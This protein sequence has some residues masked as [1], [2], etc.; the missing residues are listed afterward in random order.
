MKK[1]LDEQIASV[2]REIVMR[3]RVYKRWVADGRMTQDQASH[4]IACM[5]EV[6]RTLGEIRR[7]HDSVGYIE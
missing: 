6:L 7:K 2:Q 5:E 4:E 3:N 1:T